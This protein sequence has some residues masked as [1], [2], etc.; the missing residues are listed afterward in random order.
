MRS[1]YQ[2]QWQRVR[3][4]AQRL[5]QRLAVIAAAARDPR[6]PMGVRW[7]ALAVV[8]YALSP[9]DLIPDFIPILGYLDDVIL[10]PLGLWLVWRWIPP[11]VRED[12]LARV[13]KGQRLP[14]SRI[15]LMMVVGLWCVLAFGLWVALSG[16]I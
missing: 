9:L 13:A 14:A 12:H 11:A 10:V 7:L 3:G 5:K 4:W 16:A 15:G 1:W 6:T 8:A 2:S